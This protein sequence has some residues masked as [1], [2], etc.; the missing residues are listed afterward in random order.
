MGFNPEFMWGNGYDVFNWFIDIV[1]LCDMIL[2][3]F[4]TF[5]NKRGQEIWDS[6]VIAKKYIYSKRFIMDFLAL[7]G[8]NAVSRLNPLFKFFNL[9]KISRVARVNTYINKLNIT[10]EVKSMIQFCKLGFYL[11]LCLH[12]QG[13]IWF[14]IVKDSATPVYGTDADG[15]TIFDE[16]KMIWKPN[17]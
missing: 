2:S 1:F 4:S 7:L 11:I 5:Q 8:N 13:C 14:T 12:I 15:N 16:D 10:M 3:F 6:Q 9:M 17:S